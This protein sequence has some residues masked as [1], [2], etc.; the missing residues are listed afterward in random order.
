MLFSNYDAAK[1]LSIWI[2]GTAALSLA[3]RVHVPN[4]EV[5]GIGVIVWGQ[6]MIIRYL[7]P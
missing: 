3:Q 2:C 1:T 7:D 6:Y 5:F 4:S